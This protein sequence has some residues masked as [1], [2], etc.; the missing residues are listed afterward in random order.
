[1]AWWRGSNVAF[2]T[3]VVLPG[4]AHEDQHDG[5][6][7]TFRPDLGASR[8]VRA[9]VARLTVDLLFFVSNSSYL[10]ALNSYPQNGTIQ[11]RFFF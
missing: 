2:W 1:M 9:L 4:M 11:I 5:G 7:R 3:G 10:S 6:R 8:C